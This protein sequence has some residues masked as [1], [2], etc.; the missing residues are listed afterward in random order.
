M[1]A[2]I[3]NPLAG[4][5]RAGR[6][7]EAVEEEL[8]RLGLDHRVQL[9]R[10]LDHAQE[11]AREA[12]AAGATAV[13]F[14]GDGLI[15]AIAA[16][17]RDSGGVLGVLPGGRGNDF[18]RSL[19]I[20]LDPRAACGVLAGGMVRALD[21]GEA[22]GRPFVGIASCGFDSEANRIANEA[23][24]IRG[25]LVYAYG[26]LRALIGW[27]PATFELTADGGEARRVTGYTVA[28]ANAN[29]YGGGMWLAP[30]AALDDGMLDVVIVSHV[31]KLRFLRLLP[32]VFRGLHVRQPEV[33]V[34]RAREIEISA[35]R[36]FTLYADG[37]PIAALP[38][39]VRAVP[40]A[41]RVIVP[42]DAQ[43]AAPAAAAAQPGAREP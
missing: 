11:L 36:P 1:L 22:D 30:D 37:D 38:A 20:P 29:A 41:I 28:A 17:V 21:L 8:R 7:L 2:L 9:T 19:G 13:A 31:P 42:P 15:G 25:N 4:G 32:T 18:I 5:G 24:V 6:Q 34:L 10:S 43:R 16:A 39:T 40:G 12:G 14:G 3:V 23:K 33:E 27:R 26:A 35:S